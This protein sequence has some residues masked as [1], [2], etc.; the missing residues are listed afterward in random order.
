[1]S[2]VTPPAMDAASGQAR[3]LALGRRLLTGS[4]L[5]VPAAW[6]L[7]VLL[8]VATCITSPGFFSVAHTQELVSQASVLG[9]LAISQTFVL[10]VGGVDLSV[11]WTMTM[12]AIITNSMAP[13]TG[14][15]VAMAVALAA[16]IGVGV[17]NGLGVSAL[18]M[19]PIV[20]TL[21]MNGIVNGA[22]SSLV[23]GTGFI[24]SPNSLVSF[25]SGIVIGVPDVVWVWLGLSVIAIAVLRGTVFGRAVYATGSSQRVAWL[26][27]VRWRPVVTGCYAVSGLVAGLT[28][29]LLAGTLSQTY[30]GMGD[31]YLFP[32]IAAAVL[33][34]IAISGGSGG[35]IGP[36]GGALAITALDFLLSALGLSGQ[37]QEVGFGIVLLVAIGVPR[38]IEVLRGNT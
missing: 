8:Y 28:G 29:V 10:L 1:V 36:L 30:L 18:G 17:L 22:V 15:P 35:Y 16:S 26:S 38:A 14:L 23:G 32:S 4:D 27:G 31:A 33:G 3:P 25:T 20:M 19:S 6:V 34:G 21:A 24:N 37:A 9:M 12:A 11:P 13:S 2:A 5:L 7:A